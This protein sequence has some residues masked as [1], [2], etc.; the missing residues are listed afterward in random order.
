M[1]RQLTV[2]GATVIFGVA[3]MA[4]TFKQVARLCP[5]IRNVILLGPPQEGAVS[6]QQMA[7]DSGDLFNENLDVRLLLMN[8]LFIMKIQIIINIILLD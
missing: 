5:T 1:A 4:E 3:P 7:Q 6:F 8:F 2:V